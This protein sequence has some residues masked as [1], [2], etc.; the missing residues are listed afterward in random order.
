ME[1]SESEDEECTE[2]DGAPGTDVAG[3]V[4]QS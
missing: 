2:S 4:Q 3:T 1:A